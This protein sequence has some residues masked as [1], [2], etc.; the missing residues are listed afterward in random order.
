MVADGEEKLQGYKPAA[1]MW[2]YQQLWCKAHSTGDSEKL[3][4]SHHSCGIGI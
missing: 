3:D 4:G 1:N 2:G